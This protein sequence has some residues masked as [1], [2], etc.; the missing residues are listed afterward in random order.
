[1]DLCGRPVVV[2]FDEP[3]VIVENTEFLEDLVEVLDA[4]EGLDPEK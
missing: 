4:G 1:M 3:L 2:A